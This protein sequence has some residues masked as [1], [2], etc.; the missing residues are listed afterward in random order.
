MI[1][2]FLIFFC[3]LSEQLHQIKRTS[4]AKIICANGDDIEYVQKNVFRGESA[5]YV[6][7]KFPERHK[8]T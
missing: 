2:Y 7:K 4:F 8:L 5:R 1:N 6:L 3:Y